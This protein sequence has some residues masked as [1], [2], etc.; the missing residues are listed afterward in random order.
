M[1]VREG[2]GSHDNLNTTRD[3]QSIS[4]SSKLC[5][6]SHKEI[7]NFLVLKFLLIPKIDLFLDHPWWK[8]RVIDPRPRRAYCL[9]NSFFFSPWNMGWS[10]SLGFLA[11]VSNKGILCMAA[12]FRTKS[13]GTWMAFL[14]SHYFQGN[15]MSLTSKWH[16]TPLTKVAGCESCHAGGQHEF[17]CRNTV[18]SSFWTSL[19]LLCS[20]IGF[21]LAWTGSLDSGFHACKRVFYHL[22]HA[23]SPFCSGYFGDEVLQTIC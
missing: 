3:S 18:L 1:K 14:K 16:F 8:P 6:R 10:L 21:F 5:N 15:G 2:Q 19:V 7:F 17:F 13:S 20:I 4:P 11:E 9:W 23:S 22:S 12:S